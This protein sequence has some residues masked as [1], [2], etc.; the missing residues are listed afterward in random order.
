M[1][2]SKREHDSMSTNPSSTHPEERHPHVPGDAVAAPRIINERADQR[3]GALIGGISA[4]GI[5][6]GIALGAL[7]GLVAAAFP[8]IDWWMGLIIGGF[9]GAVL[10]VFTAAR[11]GLRALEDES[12]PPS[13]KRS[14]EPGARDWR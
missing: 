7:V 11:L 1:K 10:V 6:V 8:V 2:L 9:A 4:V 14:G 3:E 12:L 5:V 13:V